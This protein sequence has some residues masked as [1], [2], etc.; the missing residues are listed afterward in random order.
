MKSASRKKNSQKNDRFQAPMRRNRPNNE[1]PQRER[2]EPARMLKT[3]PPK[4]QGRPSTPDIDYFVRDLM[5]SA[6]SKGFAPTIMN[7]AAAELE[8]KRGSTNQAEWLKLRRKAVVETIYF[9]GKVLDELWKAA[10]RAALDKLVGAAGLAQYCFDNLLLRSPT[11]HSLIV[12]LNN[13]QAVAEALREIGA[14]ERKRYLDE[15]KQEL[16]EQLTRTCHI[17]QREVAKI[18]KRSDRTVRNLIKKGVFE[19]CHGHVST[20]SVC[21]YMKL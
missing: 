2:G 5:E 3:E 6:Q 17:T 15:D 1:T 12:T 16:R 10:Y 8:G 19:L 11:F 13:A 14:A 21:G 7:G 9:D 20:V 18:I 4:L